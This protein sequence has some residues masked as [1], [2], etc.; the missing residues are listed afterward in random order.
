MSSFHHVSKQAHYWCSQTSSVK[1]STTS[2]L[3][4]VFSSSWPM[5]IIEVLWPRLSFCNL[6]SPP[7]DTGMLSRLA[8]SKLT[9]DRS[10][11]M[12]MASISLDANLGNLPPCWPKQESKH[13]LM[14]TSSKLCCN[15]KTF[16]LMPHINICQSIVQESEYCRSKN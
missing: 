1:D 5:S 16:I 11:S 14:K 4:K 8:I 6:N 2:D 7:L 12:Y 3:D 9:E 10:S 13:V 15:I